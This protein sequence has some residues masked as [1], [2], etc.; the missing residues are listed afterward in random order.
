VIVVS[1]VAQRM[2]RQDRV[3]QLQAQRLP[4]PASH[5]CLKVGSGH[6][7]R[8]FHQHRS[9]SAERNRKSLGRTRRAVS[10][11]LRQASKVLSGAG[12]LEKREGERA[13]HEPDQ[14]MRC[15]VQSRCRG[16]RDNLGR[17][18]QSRP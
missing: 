18:V 2:K 12:S 11:D 9:Q 1:R 8:T 5:G 16:E 14:G 3:E 10:Q 4:E 15:G 13:R 7:S 6:P 17:S